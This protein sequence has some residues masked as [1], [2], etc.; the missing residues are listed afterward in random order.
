MKGSQFC[1]QA[2]FVRVQ[3]QK[4]KKFNLCTKIVADFEF[5]YESWKAKRHFQNIPILVAN[6]NAG[7]V[8]DV[9]E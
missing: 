8:S 4:L 1:H 7:G 5:F 2:T 9:K 3:Y 6:Y